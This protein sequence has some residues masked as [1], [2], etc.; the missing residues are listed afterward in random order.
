M[1]HDECVELCFF[2]VKSQVLS[3]EIISGSWSHGHLVTF[4]VAAV[5][6]PLSNSFY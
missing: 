1:I 6:F 5:Q 4:R 3:V 2:R